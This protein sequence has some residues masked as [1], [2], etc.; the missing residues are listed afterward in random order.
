MRRFMALIIFGLNLTQAATPN[1]QTPNPGVGVPLDVAER[2]AAIVSDIR[3]GLAVSIPESVSDPIIGTSVIRF[4]LSDTSAPLVL[5][6]ETSRDRVKS[7]DANG[8]SAF[9]FVNGHIVVPAASLRRGENTITIEFVARDAS[10][11]RSADFMY[12]LFV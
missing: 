8:A 12:T 9:D 4:A 6:F 3:Y 10:L 5:D 11:N 2:R 1:A 7:L